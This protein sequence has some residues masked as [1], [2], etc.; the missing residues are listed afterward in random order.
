V[1][2]WHS[3]QGLNLHPAV[4]ETAAP[5]L[6]LR[7]FIE[8]RLQGLNLQPNGYEPSALPVELKRHK[9]GGLLQL[10]KKPP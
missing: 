8:C 4:L 9:N 6:E 5:S 10:L 3:R 1:R 7:E 2:A